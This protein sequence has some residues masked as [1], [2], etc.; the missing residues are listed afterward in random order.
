VERRAFVASEYWDLEAG[1]RSGA[2]EFKAKLARLGGRRVASGQDFDATTGKLKARDVEV[3][4]R[5]AATALAKDLIDRLPWRVSKMESRPA[6][7][8]PSPPFTTSTLQQE[9]NRKLGYGAERT[10]RIAQR[11]Y[12]GI[13]LGG[14]ERV[15]LITYMRT[16]SFT[17][18]DRALGE[19]R[20]QIVSLYGEKYAHPKGPRRYKTKTRNAQEAHE[21][22]RPTSLARRPQDVAP[23]LESDEARVYELIWK[24]TIA[25]QMADAALERTTL[26]ITATTADTRDAVFTASGKKILFPGFLRAYVEGSD[27]PGA[28]LGDQESIL[29]DLREGQQ[30]DRS[31][32]SPARV[33]T[34]DPKQHVTVP[35]ARYTEASLVKK[36][37]EEG[38]G[39]PSTYA[40][41]ISTIQGRGYV[42]PQGKALVPTFVAMAV[43]NLLRTHFTDY[44]DL[45]FTARLEEELDEIAEGG[46]EWI[47]HLRAFYRGGGSNGFAR[48]QGLENVIAREVEKIGLPDVALGEDP[49]TGLKL[50]VRIGRYGPYVARGEGGEGNVGNIPE[51]IA[52]ADFRIEDALA[53][54]AAKS[55]G[56]RVVGTDPKSGEKVFAAVGRFGPYVQLG[57]GEKPRRASLPKGMDPEAADLELA[58][59]LLSLPRELGADPETGT[60]ILANIGRFGPY[61]QKDRDFRSLKA[62]DDVYTITFERA[63]E[64]LAE[65]KGARRGAAAKTVLKDLGKGPGG[66]TIQILDGRYGPY[67]T[68]GTVNATVP[69]TT[70]P[71]DV[72]MEQAMALLSAK[73]KS[74]AKARKGAAKKAAAPKKAAAK[75][76]TKKAAKKK[77]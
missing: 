75:K 16:D 1:L 22:I 50:A 15:G 51:K 13:D 48:H 36:L 72:T 31:P 18:S 65:P 20:D 42:F 41:I 49:A 60:P 3:L 10:M 76:A 25:S 39:R 62:G 33:E 40:S 27:D 17:L 46:S 32:G 4:G 37:E 71:T 9:A 63:L 77:A 6:S 38:I 66:E 19:A 52:P 70:T 30:L 26:E 34:L 69:S 47:Q 73:G 29:P 21:A 59:K 58:L 7:Q 23:F 56:P 28:E 67:I 57:T 14:G 12:E 44:V 55:E 54:I 61:V 74:P 5:D 45:K 11:L 8:S 53:A 35:P 43:T 64:L 2:G 68:D 24:R